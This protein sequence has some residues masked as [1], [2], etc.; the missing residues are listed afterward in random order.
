MPFFGCVFVPLSLKPSS[1]IFTPPPQFWISYLGLRATP[2][3]HGNNW[4]PVNLFCE[5]SIKLVSFPFF[6]PISHDQPIKQFTCFSRRNNSIS[7]DPSIVCLDQKWLM[8]LRHCLSPRIRTW[9]SLRSQTMT[10]INWIR[11]NNSTMWCCFTLRL[12]QSL[13]IGYLSFQ[14][15][16]NFLGIIGLTGNC[17]VFILIRSNQIFRRLPSSKIKVLWL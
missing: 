2:L 14:F 17:L 10:M 5:H 16:I 1:L 3:R 8:W 11:N 9:I 7:L 15:L 12:C 4:T 13:V 6:L